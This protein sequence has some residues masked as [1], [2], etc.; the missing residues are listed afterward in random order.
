MSKF[1]E[2]GKILKTIEDKFNAILAAL[3]KPHR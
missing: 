3:K 2:L 1:I